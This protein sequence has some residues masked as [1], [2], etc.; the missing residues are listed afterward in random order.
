[1]FISE[2][3]TVVLVQEARIISSATRRQQPLVTR[4]MSAD[5]RH[6]TV[7]AIRLRRFD[8]RETCSLWDA[9][10]HK[11]QVPTVPI[12]LGV[13][14][15]IYRVR[16]KRDISLRC[17]VTHRFNCQYWRKRLLICR[18]IVARLQCDPTLTRGVIYTTGVY[19]SR[20][21]T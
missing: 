3:K 1:M 10:L 13:A 6:W 14:S 18:S 2:Y 5:R 7:E 20:N 16:G 17:H 12:I 4:W 21:R 15:I 11:E 9:T 19:S 8:K